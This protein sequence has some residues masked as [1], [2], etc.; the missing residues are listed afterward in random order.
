VFDQAAY[1]QANGYFTGTAGM[2][3]DGTGLSS[4][5]TAGFSFE[6]LSAYIWVRNGDDPVEGTEWFLARADSWVFPDA[7]PGCCDNEPNA[8]W[9]VSEL[10]GGDVPVWGSQG[11]ITGNG[12][13]TVTGNHSLQTFTFVP[14][15]SSPLLS[16]LAV[17]LAVL[18]RRR[19]A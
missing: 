16:A 6:G 17:A 7:V 5:A 14:E 13:Y 3:D 9:S 2:A 10:D 11:G 19:A 15:P 4:H 12:S 8:Q 18:R 1:N